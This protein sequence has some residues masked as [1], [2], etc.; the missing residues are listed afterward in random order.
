MCLIVVVDIEH[1]VKAAAVVSAHSHFLRK[2]LIAVTC[3][4]P[5]QNGG[6]CYQPNTCRCTPGWTNTTCESG[7]EAIVRLL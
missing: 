6:T 5:C 4:E 1:V 7:I 2:L 3:D